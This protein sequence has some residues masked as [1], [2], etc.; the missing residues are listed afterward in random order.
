MK[1]ATRRL[2]EEQIAVVV[3]LESGKKD[4]AMWHVPQR[5]SELS[6][7]VNIAIYFILSTTYMLFEIVTSVTKTKT[8]FELEY[9]SIPSLE[10]NGIDIL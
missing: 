9:F 7:N 2:L 1:V 5:H 4:D 6:L 3:V 8:P 10:Q